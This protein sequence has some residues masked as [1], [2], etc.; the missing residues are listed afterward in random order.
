MTKAEVELPGWCKIL[1]GLMDEAEN[2]KNKE[3]HSKETECGEVEASGIS[4][5]NLGEKRYIIG[6]EKTYRQIEKFKVQLA[7]QQASLEA[8]LK[9]VKRQYPLVALA[10]AISEATIAEL[11]SKEMGALTVSSIYGALTKK[12]QFV[13]GTVLHER[14][15]KLSNCLGRATTDSKTISCFEDFAKDTW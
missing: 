2:S 14:M 4:S 12:K 3:N 13:E 7:S 6:Y 11:S 8:Q 1:Q 9:E 15:T 10:Y 5:I